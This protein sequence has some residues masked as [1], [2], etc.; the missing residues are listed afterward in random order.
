MFFAPAIRNNSSTAVPGLGLM[1]GAFERFMQGA[2]GGLQQP[3]QGMEEDEKSW[4]ISMDLPGVGREQVSVSVEGKLVRIETSQ[5]ARRQFKALYELPQEIN[6][7]GSE[8]KL[9]NGVLT[10]R[11]AKVEPV[12]SGRQ[13]EVH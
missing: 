2:F 5:D 3:W 12:A 10:L 6:A 7:E 4:T 8:A 11:L 9:E 13:I 1:D